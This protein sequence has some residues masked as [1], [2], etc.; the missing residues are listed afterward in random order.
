MYKG[1]AAHHKAPMAEAMG[2]GGG[3]QPC[4]SRREGGRREKAPHSMA[5]S[6]HQASWVFLLPL[7]CLGHL[8]PAP[9]MP[10]SAGSCPPLLLPCLGQLGPARP[11]SAWTRAFCSRLAVSCCVL[12]RPAWLCGHCQPLTVAGLV[13]LS[14]ETVPWL[15]A[16]LCRA[17]V[18]LR[19]VSWQE[20]QHRSIG[21]CPKWLPTWPCVHMALHIPGVC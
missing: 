10:W 6:Q 9:A 18:S 11:C 14:G 15:H 17:C 12:P 20:G 1:P 19:V 21:D 13:R 8:G 4:L 2:V 7:P 5:A 3:S 16:A